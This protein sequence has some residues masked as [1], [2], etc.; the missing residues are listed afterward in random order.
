MPGLSFYLAV[1]PVLKGAYVF[2]FNNCERTKELA[3][4]RAEQW[5][6]SVTKDLCCQ[7]EVNLPSL[8]HVTKS[9]PGQAGSTWTLGLFRE[10]QT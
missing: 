10:R 3:E 1:T 8:R 2:S 5:T 4:K 9:L 6:L 7:S